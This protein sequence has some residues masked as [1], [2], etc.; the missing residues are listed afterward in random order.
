MKRVLIALTLSLTAAAAHGHFVFVVPSADGTTAQVVFSD[1]L[2]P[3]ENVDVG[4]IA[5]TKLFVRDAAGKDTV[6]AW[7][8]GA[9]CLDVAVAVKEPRLVY[10]HTDYGVLQRGSARPFLLQY[11]PKAILGAATSAAK[12]GDA[13]PAEVVPLADGGKVR[14]LVLSR[15][16]PAAGAEVNVLLPGGNG[17]KKMTTDKEGRTGPVGVNGR[18]GVWARVAEA[19]AGERDGKKY[20]EVRRYATLVA[21]FGEGK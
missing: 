15:G 21:D 19:T 8:K 11:Y 7:K 17:W 2:A 4:K 13:L 12:V 18:V 3:D 1:S 16:K 20:E 5:G 6:A 10:G 14:F 9:H